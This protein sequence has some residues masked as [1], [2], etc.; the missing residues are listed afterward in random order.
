[1]GVRIVLA[2]GN[3]DQAPDIDALPQL[4]SDEAT[5]FIVV[6]AADYDGSRRAGSQGGDQLTIY[7]P[8]DICP[9]QSRIDFEEVNDS[10]TSIGT[11]GHDA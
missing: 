10:G 5:P 9:L 3:N 8:G 4:L 11:F 1:M 7:A 6:G 2:S